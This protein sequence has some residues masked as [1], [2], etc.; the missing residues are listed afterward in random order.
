M[1]RFF[2]KTLVLMILMQG[3]LVGSQPLFALDQIFYFFSLKTGQQNTGQP[4]PLIGQETQYLDEIA[5]T[6]GKLQS[7]EVVSP[8]GLSF[9]FYRVDGSLATGF[10]LE[11]HWYS[12]LYE[13]K[14]KSKVQLETQAVLFGFSTY[15]RGDYWFPFF[16]LGT[17]T[18][19]TKIREKLSATTTTVATKASFIDS[20]RSVYYYELGSRFPFGDWGLMSSLRFTSANVKVQ[21]IGERLELGGQTLF[22]GGYFSY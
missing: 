7:N 5:K 1:V 15:Y 14:D 8:S 10:G 13:F 3:I 18:Y 6:H 12:K 22:F 4:A 16:A 17:G 2:S 9:D 20:A 21:T 19:N 11:T